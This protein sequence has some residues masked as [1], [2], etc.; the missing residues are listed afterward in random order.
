MPLSSG[1]DTALQADAPLMFIAVELDFPTFTLRLVDGAGSVTFGGNTF[2][3]PDPTYGAIGTIDTITDGTTGQAPH[4]NMTILP[5]SLAAAGALAAA[6]V[7]GSTVSIWLGAVTRSTGQVVASPDLMFAGFVDVPTLMVS[8]QSRAVSLDLA[9][10]WELFFD[11]DDGLGLNN[12][13]HQA[14]WPGELGCSFV[15]EID[16]QVAWGFQNPSTVVPP[17]SGSS[18]LFKKIKTLIG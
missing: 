12:I 15:T 5:P 8:G 2:T 17:P 1:M 3:A 11:A 9:S 4:F 16:R 13:S 7:Q 10:E 14:I 18:L 6:A